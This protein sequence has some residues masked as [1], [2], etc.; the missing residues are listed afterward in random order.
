MNITT[1]HAQ[2]TVADSEGS[3]GANINRRASGYVADLHFW[4]DSVYVARRK[5]EPGLH[6][7]IAPSDKWKRDIEAEDFEIIG[8]LSDLVMECR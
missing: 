8:K 7:M 3:C 2:I 6:V 5:G 4:G 1:T